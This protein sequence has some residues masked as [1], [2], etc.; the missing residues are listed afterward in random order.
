M[1]RYQSFLMLLAAAVLGAAVPAGAA[2]SAAELQKETALANPYPNDFGPATLTD[3]QLKDYPADIKEGYQLLLTRCSQCHTSAR[4]LNSRFVEPA[5]GLKAKPGPARDSAETAAISALKK[6]HPE[7]FKDPAVWQ[8]EAG[9]WSRYVKRMLSKPGCGVAQGGHMTP[10]EAL[11]IY[12]FLTYDGEHR[13]LG[14]NADAWKAHRAKLVEEL[15][16]KKP[17]RYDELK[18]DNDL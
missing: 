15:K 11:K 18:K 14:A 5:A 6:S 8:I 4:P 9:V 1:K 10:A 13:K 7:Y 12:T 2:K 16:A 3:E 17:A